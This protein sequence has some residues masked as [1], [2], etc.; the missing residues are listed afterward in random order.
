MEFVRIDVPI[1]TN[2]KLDLAESYRI[3]ANNNLLVERTMYW[4]T[5]SSYLNEILVVKKMPLI[6][7]RIE[8]TLD[9]FA[10]KNSFPNILTFP[11]IKL[12]QEPISTIPLR[13]KINKEK[14]FLF[15]N[16]IFIIV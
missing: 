5:T 1:C 6:T 11:Y 15:D 2:I 12:N 14:R 4:D 16:V 13:T 7:L 8:N 9:N 3:Y 10:N